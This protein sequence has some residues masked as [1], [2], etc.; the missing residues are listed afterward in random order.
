[1][2]DAYRP[3][4]HRAMLFLM[5]ALVLPA[6]ALNVYRGGGMWYP[7][8]VGV[9]AALMSVAVRVD[10]RKIYRWSLVLLAAVSVLVFAV[11]VVRF[12][13][14]TRFVHIPNIRQLVPALLF[15]ALPAFAALLHLGGG[16]WTI[17]KT[18]LAVGVFVLVPLFAA[19]AAG[20]VFL[21]LSGV[22]VAVFVAVMGGR[23]FT[24][25]RSLFVFFVVLA[26]IAFAVVLKASSAHMP[27]LEV[28]MSRGASDP[29]G[30]GYTNI[31]I[32]RLLGSSNW[33]GPAS[34]RVSPLILNSFPV[35]A[36]IAYFGRVA[37]I[38]FVLG[39][40]ALV[41]VMFHTAGKIKSGY[42]YFVF[43]LVCANFT[44]RYLVGT[45]MAFG[46]FPVFDVDLP[47]LSTKGPVV[48][49]DMLLFGLML[50]VWRQNDAPEKEAAFERHWAEPFLS[51]SKSISEKFLKW[52]GI[53]D[54][55]EYEG[56]ED[57]EDLSWE[58]DEYK[59]PRHRL[60]GFSPGFESHREVRELFRSLE[61][62][63]EAFGKWAAED[64]NMK[65]LNAY[66]R[67][68]D[69]PEDILFL[70]VECFCKNE[71]YGEFYFIRLDIEYL[72]QKR[73]ECFFAFFIDRLVSVC[74]DAAFP[75]ERFPVRHLDEA[76]ELFLSGECVADETVQ[77]ACLKLA[78]KW[79]YLR[80]YGMRRLPKKFLG[81][82]IERLCAKP[83]LFLEKCY[84][85]FLA[86]CRFEDYG[87]KCAP[88]KLMD[89][90]AAYE[91]DQNTPES[92]VSSIADILEREKMEK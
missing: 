9:S 73:D 71:N 47:L 54:G 55:G 87:Q 21:F 62:D 12:G 48:F 58:Y 2:D 64:E 26:A 59:P 75:W 82:V 67:R 39:V 69:V 33:F 15:F 91:I 61:N 60:F 90:C 25:S 36:V 57:F 77:A 7:A 83:G 84:L 29:L 27:R 41:A 1:M 92:I 78:A 20:S 28:F 65:M 81:D 31:Q 6:A 8:A 16:W 43:L 86:G 53:G 35:L 40:L 24:V 70:V 63:R 80:D 14:A 38:A 50:S 22:F 72:L 52:L 17:V 3:Q 34:D 19:H 76:L 46:F 10:Y 49:S 4:T 51:L 85:E 32:D 45:L 88:K 30:A 74:G 68:Y 79:R 56:F 18:G 42:G 5:A 37:G 89:F 44:V 11:A 66:L 13:G 23:H